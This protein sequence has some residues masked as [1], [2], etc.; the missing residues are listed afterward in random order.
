[1]ANQNNYWSNY[2]TGA[3][4]GPPLV[5]SDPSNPNYV[6]P[7]QRV[8]IAQNIAQAGGTIN[9]YLPQQPAPP[10]PKPPGQMSMGQAP[11]VSSSAAPGNPYA[12]MAGSR[13]PS[14]GMLQQGGY[15]PYNN[16]NAASQFLQGGAYGRNMY[17]PQMQQPGANMPMSMKT[18]PGFGG[19]FAPNGQ[20]TGGS[21]SGLSPVDPSIPR[22]VAQTADQSAAIKQQFADIAAAGNAHAAPVGR[23]APSRTGAKVSQ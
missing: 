18:N 15:N 22:G 5:A 1:M 23:A 14:P 7:D 8:G 12:Q 13:S 6:P 21:Q 4:G 10:P 11:Q 16:S 2:V 19:F 3:A 20:F 9:R 17:A